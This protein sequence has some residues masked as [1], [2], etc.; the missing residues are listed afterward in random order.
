MSAGERNFESMASISWPQRLESAGG[1]LLKATN[2][3]M[4]LR[5]EVHISSNPTEGIGYLTAILNQIRRKRPHEAA[6]AVSSS[7]YL[8]HAYP[9]S[10]TH[11]QTAR[12]DRSRSGDIRVKIIIIIASR[13]FIQ[14]TSMLDALLSKSRRPA[15]AP[16]VGSPL[17]QH[18]ALLVG[19]LPQPAGSELPH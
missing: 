11:H 1:I 5:Q 3:R 19:I 17:A 12:A 10:Q 15:D 13:L 6:N 16:N 2:A 9:L 7:T 8:C 4:I 18:T 14:K